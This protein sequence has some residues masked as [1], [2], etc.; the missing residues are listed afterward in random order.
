MFS[1]LLLTSACAHPSESPPPSPATAQ[2]AAASAGDA[3][4]P[5]PDA[6]LVTEVDA[7][8]RELVWPTTAESRCDNPASIIQLAI[9]VPEGLEGTGDVVVLLMHRRYGQPAYAGHPHFLWRFEDQPLSATEPVMVQVDMCDGNAVMWSEENCEYNLVA[10]VDK[11]DNN[12]LERGAR[13][14]VPD[15]DEPARLQ[16][17]EQSCRHEGPYRFELTLDCLDGPACVRH[18]EPPA[19]R[20]AETSCESESRICRR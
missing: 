3:E 15:P 7:G 2:D 16:V 5:T 1:A 12:R 6:G 10:I 11:N 4:A 18:D 19:C 20:C 14:A 17:F 8:V 9:T 13:L